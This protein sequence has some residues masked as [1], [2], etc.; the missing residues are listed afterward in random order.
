M[1]HL[2]RYSQQLS[3][4]LDAQTAQQ[5]GLGAKAVIDRQ[6]GAIAAMMEHAQ[7]H[8]PPWNNQVGMSASQGTQAAAEQGLPLPPRWRPT[9]PSFPQL[10]PGRPTNMEAVL[11][12]A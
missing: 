10:L 9:S 6:N 1:Q 3:G 11:C 2:Q 5:L 4:P 7:E 12:W 8:G